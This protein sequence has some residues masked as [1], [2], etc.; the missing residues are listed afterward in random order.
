MFDLNIC[1][2][3]MWHILMCTIKTKKSN[4][5]TKQCTNLSSQG[6]NLNN[7]IQYLCQIQRNYLLY[8]QIL[9]IMSH[10]FQKISS[11]IVYDTESQTLVCLLLAIE[12][13]LR[14]VA[15]ILRKRAGFFTGIQFL[16]GVHQTL[17]LDVEIVTLPTDYTNQAQQY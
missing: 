5:R 9:T 7:E 2:K 14:S 17:V 13:T 12:L 1:K 6:V 11:L 10:V 15:A 4:T 16:I 3:N 8:P